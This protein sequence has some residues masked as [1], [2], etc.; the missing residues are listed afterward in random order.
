MAL[1]E[2]PADSEV[3]HKNG[4]SYRH[5]KVQQFKCPVKS[6]GDDNVAKGGTVAQREVTDLVKRIKDKKDAEFE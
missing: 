6:F 1:D 3:I 4:V 2:Q 5:Q